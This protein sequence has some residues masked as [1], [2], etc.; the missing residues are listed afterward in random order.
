MRIF[1]AANLFLSI[2]PFA[3]AA[4]DSRTEPSA[5]PNPVAP[6]IAAAK[7]SPGAAKEESKEG[8]I[9]IDPAGAARPLPN[10]TGEKRE[11]GTLLS[12][13]QTRQ[14]SRL[15]PY[16]PT[17]VPPSIRTNLPP[18]HPLPTNAVPT[19][20]PGPGIGFPTNR[21]TN[22]PPARPRP[23]GDRPKPSPPSPPVAE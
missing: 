20:A 15:E 7:A 13:N 21:F 2:G 8:T 11:A 18:V 6:I 9:I 14:A 16:Q 12:T 17:N 3:L 1:A 4:A 23:P 22:F 19:N 5:A 10:A